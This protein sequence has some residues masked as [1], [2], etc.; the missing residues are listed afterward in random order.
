MANPIFNRLENQWDS[1]TAVQH[2]PSSYDQK[3]FEQAQASYA[4]PAATA[5]QMG[6]MTY[7]DVI[8]RSAMSFGVLL[9]FAFVGWFGAIA[10]P[11]LATAMIFGGIGIGLVLVFVNVF[12]KTVRPG[13]VLAYA[14]AEG[15]ALG[16][17]SLVMNLLYPGVVVQ[18]VVATF[19]VF[20]VTLALFV[21]GKVR[22]S[23]KMQ[24]FALISLV[25]LIVSRLA[26]WGLSLA[27]VP[28][29]GAGEPSIMGLPLGLLLGFFAVFIG[30]ICLIGDFD[31]IRTG[32]Q[33][34]APAKDAWMAAFGLMITV[35]WLYVEILNIFARLQ[36]R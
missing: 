17:L 26:I 12:S 20:G 21:S 29:S 6:R 34:G 32:V 13:A 9:A 35:V 2:Q 4:G 24:K 1:G 28:M 11:Q 18:A 22:N 5:T 16:S 14:A 10:F 15:L 30:A 33:K 25:G 36:S 31:Q 3:A 19:A 7:D 27:G 8:V 23:P